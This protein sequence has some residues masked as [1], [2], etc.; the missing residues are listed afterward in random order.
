MISLR[1]ESAW[2]FYTSAGGGGGFGAFLL[3]GGMFVLKDLEGKLQSFDYGGFGI[4]MSYPLPKL[5]RLPQL[6]LPTITLR[7]QEFGAT[8]SIADFPSDG[9]VYVTDACHG[10][11]LTAQQ[12]E[13]GVIYFD[14]GL[15]WLRGYGGS[16]LLAGIKKELLEMGIMIPSL[17][18]L[19]IASAPAVIVMRGQN[20]GL[21]QSAGADFMLGQIQWEGIYRDD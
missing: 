2:S 14:G 16:V 3:S 15:G 20:E 10:S 12:L 21:Q 9:I 5:L 7:G 13:G 8:G 6:T 19:A 4:G 17:M 1:G 18:R 11:D